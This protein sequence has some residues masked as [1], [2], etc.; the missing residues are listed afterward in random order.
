MTWL[1]TMLQLSSA[2]ELTA[3]ALAIA[4]VVL[5]IRQSL[6]CWPAAILS[7][8]IYTWLFADGRLYMESLLQ[9]FYII[10]AI[11]GLWQWRQGKR[12]GNGPL[13]VSE[14]PLRW[15]LPWIAG[16]LAASLLLGF[17]LSVYTTAEQAYLDTLTTV[18]S[19][20]ATY[21]VARKVLENWLY[22]IVIDAAYVVLFWSKGFHA[23]ALLF[24]LYTIMAAIGFWRWRKDRINNQ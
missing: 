10:M 9:V 1:I 15:H 18:F 20:F 12:N 19:L 23:T 7:A 6:W 2:W 5:A 16:L 3:V 8:G 14:R 22:W 11:Y 17:V 4:Y 24:A 13:P 21:L